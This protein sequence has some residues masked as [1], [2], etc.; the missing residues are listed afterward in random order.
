MCCNQRA[1]S[2]SLETCT[3]KLERT[4]QTLQQ[5]PR[6]LWRHGDACSKFGS[7]ETFDVGAAFLS[8]MP[9][10]RS[11]HVRALIDGSPTVGKFPKLRQAT[12]AGFNGAYDLTEGPR[13][14]GILELV[15]G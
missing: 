11:V 6:L 8:G 5:H 9:L 14:C 3:H 13:F 1:V 10:K 7:G 2:A 12:V 4:E 15:A